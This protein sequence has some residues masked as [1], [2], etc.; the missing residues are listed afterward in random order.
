MCSLCRLLVAKNHNFGQNFDF[1][2]RLY[3]PR[4]T[5]DGQI[6]HAMADPRC[7]LMCRISSG[8][9][10]SVALGLQTLQFLPFF[11]IRHLVVSPIGS[12]LRTRVHNYKPS[13]IQR[14]KIV[15]VLQRLRGE[16]GRT[17]SDVQKR[18]GQT[19]RRTNKKLNVFGHP[20]GG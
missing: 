13:P 1:L 6:W 8:S 3:Q 2:G 16:I 9:V 18:D 20:G 5:D 19:D 10:Y 17:T 14:I 7:T 4:F 15:S 12:S 11:G